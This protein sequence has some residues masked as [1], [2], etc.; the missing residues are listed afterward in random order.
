M[1]FNDAENIV[2][3]IR[4][5]E[6]E[7]SSLDSTMSE[8][9]IVQDKRLVMP[10]SVPSSGNYLGRLHGSLTRIISQFP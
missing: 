7:I 10:L 4:I 9:G 2:Q 3:R 8:D 1:D 6:S 5:N